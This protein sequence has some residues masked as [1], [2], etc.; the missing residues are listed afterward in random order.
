MRWI[1]TFI[2]GVFVGLAIAT[3]STLWI[4]VGLLIATPAY[5][6]ETRP[7]LAMMLEDGRAAAKFFRRT[8]GRER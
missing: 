4:V 3:G 7:Q 5:L 1:S 8:V 2:G 6:A